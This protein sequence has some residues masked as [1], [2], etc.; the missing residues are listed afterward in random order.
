MVLESSGFRCDRCGKAG[1]LE[2]HHRRPLHRGGTNDPDNLETLCRSCHV[3][4]HKAE[5]EARLSPA[6]R[7]WKRLIEATI[8]EMQA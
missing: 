2:V 8:K 5:R 7:D 4:H 3:G 6:E 1:R